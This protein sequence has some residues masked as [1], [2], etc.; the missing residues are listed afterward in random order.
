MPNLPTPI[1]THRWQRWLRDRMVL[2]VTNLDTYARGYYTDS[3][4]AVS[5]PRKLVIAQALGH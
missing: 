4:S 2:R 3:I 5:K 1:R